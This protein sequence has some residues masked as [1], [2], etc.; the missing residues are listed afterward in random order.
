MDINPVIPTLAL[1][2]TAPKNTDLVIVGLLDGEDGLELVGGDLTAAAFEKV[3]GMSLL[4][5]AK[6]LGASAKSGSTVVLPGFGGPRVLVVGVGTG[7][8]TPEQVRRAAGAAVRAA[9]AFAEDKPLTLAIDLGTDE[10]ELVVGA[11]E[12][13]AFGAHSQTKVTSKEAKQKI[14]AITIVSSDKSAQ[15]KSALDYAKAVALAMATCRDWVNLPANYLYPETFAE[16]AKTHATRGVKVDIWEPA[17][18]EKEGFGGILAVGNG[19]ARKPRLV[20]AS[21]AP[22]GAKFHLALVGKGITFDSGGLDIK[23][24]DGMYTMKCDMAGAA[25]VLAAT[26]AIAELGLKIKVTCWASM[27]ENMPSGDAY[28]PSDVLTMYGGKTVENANTDAEGRLVMADAI[29]RA[30]ED[31]PDLIIDVATLTGA[32]IVALGAKT[33]GLM[34]S[35]DQTAD[36]IL[37]AAESAGEAF[38][39]LPIPEGTVESLESKIADIKSSSGRSGGALAAAAF[40]HEFVSDDIPWAHLDI[41][42]PAFNTDAPYGYCGLGGTGHG[43]RTLVA[44]ADALAQ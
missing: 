14:G 24:A 26:N 37:D 15:V 41:A 8:G 18:L 42:G 43:L 3:S 17:R 38:W 25:T 20:R 34:A 36:L 39:Q 9:G 7:E 6:K 16:S 23:T 21:Y 30:S 1:A 5:T 2:T 13:A 35:D 31:K 44:L 19:S 28:R 22:R 4:D 27:A 40:L 33:A 10:P 11:A 12:G 29:A 32:C